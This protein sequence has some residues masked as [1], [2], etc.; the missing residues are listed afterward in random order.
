MPCLHG[1]KPVEQRPELCLLMPD[2]QSARGLQT[3]NCLVG[4]GRRSIG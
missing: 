2:R 1:I 4:D 3:L